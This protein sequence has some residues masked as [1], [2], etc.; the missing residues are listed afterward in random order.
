MEKLEKIIKNKR[1]NMGLT[2]K[3]LA[4]KTKLDIRVID[5]I[6]NG[7]LKH[8]S[9]KTLEAFSGELGLELVVLMM[10]CGYTY[11]EYEKYMIDYDQKYD[12]EQLFLF[13][14]TLHGSQLAYGKCEEELIKDIIKRINDI[15]E[16]LINHDYMYS[17]NSP[18]KPEIDINYVNA[19][20]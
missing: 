4:Y 12:H 1:I 15:L 7:R 14:I 17:D 13:D 6:E 19:N 18:I 3:E 10:A 8:P 9:I 20:K 2:R 16:H 5:K 11:D